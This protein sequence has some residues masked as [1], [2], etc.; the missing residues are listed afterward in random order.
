[1][2]T[3]FKCK[4]EKEITEFYRHPQTGD[5]FLG[6]CKEC[7]KEDNKTGNG[8]QARVCLECSKEFR[9]TLTEVN[10]GGGLTC[11]RICYYNR[12]R[13]IIKSGKDSSNWKGDNVGKA[14]LHNWVEKQRGK[15]QVCEFCKTKTA[16]KYEWSNKS[17]LYLRELSDWQR[18]CTRCHIWYD[19]EHPLSK[20]TKAR[21]SKKK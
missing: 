4:E 7:T 8:T 16:K 21:S 13:K 19:I 14:A 11:S 18:L 20:K 3:C 12:L 17:Q 9:T 10:R 5:G 2:K 15:P 1:M 6:K